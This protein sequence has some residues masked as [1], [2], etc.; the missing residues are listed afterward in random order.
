[1]PYG[2]REPHELY[3]DWKRDFGRDAPLALEIGPGRGA[4]ALDHAAR[5]PE[6][7]LK[8]FV[9]GKFSTDQTT[10]IDQQ[11]DTFVDGLRLLINRGPAEA[12][13]LLNRRDQ[14]ETDQP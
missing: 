11:L 8:D 5:H 9:L 2:C 4:F 7:D 14:N 13:N 10:L 1:M 6:M 3:P 12:M